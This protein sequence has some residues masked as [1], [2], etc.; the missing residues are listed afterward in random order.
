MLL[1][2]P[3]ISLGISYVL[4]DCFDRSYIVK[5]Y[6]NICYTAYFDLRIKL[7]LFSTWVSYFVGQ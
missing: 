5:L 4:E 2:S 3:Q 7:S 1:H 6:Y